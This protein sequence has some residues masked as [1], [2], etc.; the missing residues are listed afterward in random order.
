MSSGLGWVAHTYLV[1]MA[2]ILLVV[3][4]VVWDL[5]SIKEHV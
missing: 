5:E 1:L 4:I 2:I 3:R